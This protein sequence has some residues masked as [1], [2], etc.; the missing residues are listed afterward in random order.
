MTMKGQNRC[1]K[2]LMLPL[3][4]LLA[5]GTTLSAAH[6]TDAKVLKATTEEVR[7]FVHYVRIARFD[8][9]KTYGQ[10]I[11]D[12]MPA[13]Y[14][15]A[16]G[17]AA[18]DPTE[19]AKLVEESGES[20]RFDDAVARGSRLA[21]LETLANQ[22]GRALE[23]GKR[24]SSRLSAQIDA[25][26]AQL[27]GTQRQRLLARERLAAAGEYALPALLSSLSDRNADPS[28]RA[29]VRGLLVDMGRHAAR[30]LQAALP[31]LEPASAEL[32][33][34]ILGD[35]PSASSLPALYEVYSK[36]ESSAVR[37]AAVRSI[38]RLTGGQFNPQASVSQQYR[39]LADA[40]LAQSESL[41]PFAKEDVQ[42]V[43]SFEPSVGLVAQPIATRV[44]HETMAM[45]SAERGLKADATDRDALATWVAA[46][47][48][49]EID[50]PEG[51]VHP[52]YK[53]R[54]DAMYY[55]TAAGGEVLQAVLARALATKDAPLATRA[56]EAIAK[57]TGPAA[58]SGGKSG[59]A[60]P[61]AQAL[62]FPSRRVQMDA[63]LA[64]AAIGSGQTFDGAE[65]VVPTLAGAVREAGV[66]TA[67]V[68]ASDAE[69]GKAIGEQLRA[70]GYTVLPPAMGAADID[71]SIG[72]AAGVD[73]VA[74][75]Q[76][77]GQTG[78]TLTVARAHPVLGASPV[79]AFADAEGLAE[80][81]RVW[82]RD[83]FVKLSRAGL[84]TEELKNAAM[85]LTA[86]TIGAPLSAEQAADY[87]SRALAA[88]R[89]IAMGGAVV[90]GSSGAM[91][92]ADA[93]APLV[94]ALADAKGPQRAAIG[95]VLGLLNDARAQR[96]LVE[97]AM[98]PDAPDMA[99]MLSAATESAKRF[100]NLLEDR[101]VRQLTEAASKPAGT[102]ATAVSALLGALNVPGDR[103]VPVILGK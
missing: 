69:K 99:A 47:F 4:A 57:T 12:K 29:E 92:A 36:S 17:D 34:G 31:G 85:E 101:H 18:I 77:V 90:A 91:N 61:L 80:L 44:F 67:L 48:R 97:A 15:K 41:T 39:T 26:I 54:A 65:R 95:D 35:I 66:R 78:A 37:E 98:A 52:L 96:A 79:M 63:A 5:A 87:Q 89:D 49:R 73:L 60:R 82:D 6:A 72:S 88:L 10:A 81:G 32:V 27:T 59:G 75:A 64:L 50:A 25:N 24:T 86:R 58:M 46:N 74:V 13:P 7:D 43:W 100:G 3:V 22:L 53:D 33:A 93:A 14:G 68:V 102:G 38:S 76:G 19:F 11:L 16:E 83:G 42:P 40:Y 51:Y 21:D 55:A 1:L 70:L 2:N 45:Q 94:A 30:P 23:M 84:T 103:V 56:I 71:A 8:L 62:R 20:A 28:L 9:A